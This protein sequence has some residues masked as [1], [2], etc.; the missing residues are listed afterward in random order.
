M[1]CFKPEQLGDALT[2][3]FGSWVILGELHDNRVLSPW[4]PYGD[5][6]LCSALP[7]MIPLNPQLISMA[8]CLL[9]LPIDG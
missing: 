8:G 1:S 7:R 2:L 3:P 4:S 6:A 9:G 5:Q